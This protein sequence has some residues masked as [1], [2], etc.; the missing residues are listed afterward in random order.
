[1]PHTH[2]ASNNHRT[3]SGIQLS[4]RGNRPVAAGDH[5]RKRPDTARPRCYKTRMSTPLALDAAACYQALRTRDARF[6]GR[7][8]TGVVSTGVFCRPV[9]PAPTPKAVNCRFFACAAAAAEA[10]FRPCLRCRPET[11][12]GCPAWLGT[13]ATVTRALRLIEAGALEQS[14]PPALA[15]RLG[16]SERHLRRLF[17]KHLG[18]APATV[19]RTRR[20]L[21]AKKLLDETTLPMTEVALS[22]G[23]TSVRRFNE[24]IRTTYGRTPSELRRGRREE[25]VV[26]APDIVLRLPLRLPF[27]WSAILS[28]FAVRA[29]AGVE[30]VEAG[31]YRRTVDVDGC[32]GAIEVDWQPDQPFLVAR[33]LLAPTGGLIRVVKRLRA[34]FDLDADPE[35]IAMRLATDLRLAPLVHARPGLRVPGAWDGFETAVRGILGQQVSVPAATTLAGRLCERFG[36]RLPPSHDST[37][38]YAFPRAESL[39]RADLTALGLPSA[40]AA[41]ISTLAAAVADGALTLDGAHDLAA[42]TAALRALPGIGEWTAQYIAMRALGEPDAFPASDLGLRRA[43]GRDGSAATVDEVERTAEAWRPWRAYAAV[44]LWTQYAAA[45]TPSAARKA[46]NVARSAPDEPEQVQR[47]SRRRRKPRAVTG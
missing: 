10:G 20:I 11:A 39:A 5:V 40:R 28:F 12:P 36:R 16:V 6:D 13:S 15:S 32:L 34:L 3:R 22:A 8:F 37:L 4:V 41:A 29:I 42:T 17:L 31:V 7:F 24:S 46:P 44:H 25:R 2:T 14:D 26:G 18:A 43:L 23:F 9:C 19:A 45:R 27:D 1:M 35:H 30:S 33:L 38:R 47:R 21:F